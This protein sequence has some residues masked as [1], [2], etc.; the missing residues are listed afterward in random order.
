MMSDD[1]EWTQSARRRPRLPA[2]GRADRH[3]A[4][5]RRGGRQAGSSRPTTRSRSSSR[6]TTSSSSRP[7]RKRS[8]CR[9]TS[10]KCSMSRG[11]SARR[12]SA[13]IPTPIPT[14]TTPAP[15]SSPAAVTGGRLGRRRRLGRLGRL[16]RPLERRRRRHRLQ[17]LLQQRINGKV[18]L[19]DVD[20][21]NVDRSKI[22]FDSNQFNN[23]DRQRQSAQPHQG[24]RQHL[25]Q[26]QGADVA[27][28][29]QRRL[30]QPC[31]RGA[32]YPQEHRRGTESTPGI[33]GR[34]QCGPQPA[35]AGG[36]RGHSP[37]RYFAAR[38]QS[39]DPTGP[40][41][42]GR[43]S[44]DRPATG[45]TSPRATSSARPISIA[46][47][48]SRRWEAASTTGPATRERWAASTA[49]G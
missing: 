22:N 12:R 24:Q 18:N 48:A 41:A 17:Q 34:R 23:I 28:A 7:I 5:A 36:R 37:A 10:R 3:P 4:A 40:P 15:R 29:A 45:R 6:A 44:T 14:I 11:L 9:S 49:A 26:E 13:T 42:T 38:G 16:G 43:T 39:A 32:R 47:P 27:R 31:R 21:K 2:E 19:N 8:M 25:D 33:A 1:L 30:P 20:W 35:G 46:R